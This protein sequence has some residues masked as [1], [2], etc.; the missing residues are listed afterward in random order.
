MPT[1]ILNN[2]R[3]QRSRVVWL[4]AVIAIGLVGGSLVVD[5]TGESAA[6]QFLLARGS[7]NG[8]RAYLWVKGGLLAALVSALGVHVVSSGFA[9][10]R[11][12]R[13]SLFG[14]PLAVP[15][16]VQWGMGYV[17]VLLGS[18][19]VALSLTALVAMNA[20]RYMRLV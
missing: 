17:F 15:P 2:L 6:D 19:L 3:I 12:G 14:V 13:S 18:A 1:A 4:L 20:C 16:R 9:L 7:L 5:L 8:L 11:S 10:A